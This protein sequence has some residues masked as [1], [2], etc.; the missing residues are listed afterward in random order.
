MSTYES[1]STRRFRYGRVDNIRAASP[2][3]LKWVK[4]MTGETNVPVSN[5]KPFSLIQKHFAQSA[6]AVE[7]TDCTS[8]D[9]TPNECPD[10]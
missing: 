2:A 1:A 4:S 5:Q 8:A 9:P 10:I 3:A 6:G 7:F